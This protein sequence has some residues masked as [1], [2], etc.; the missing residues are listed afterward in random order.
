M[1]TKG[2][3]E[4]TGPCDMCKSVGPLN[5]RGEYSLCDECTQDYDT[6]DGP[7]DDE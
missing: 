7:E 2:A 1:S 3:F 4:M 6:E 5:R